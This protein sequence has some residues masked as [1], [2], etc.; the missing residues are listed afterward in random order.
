MRAFL[1]NRYGASAGAS[2]TALAVA[3][4]L[5]GCAVGPDFHAPKAPET[6]GY[7]PP[8][9]AADAPATH[10]AA[11][12]ADAANTPAAATN[13]PAGAPA[14][15]ATASGVVADS[16]QS[17]VSGLDIPGQWWT[18]FQSPQ[19]NALIERA[20]TRSPTL[21]A[22]QAALREANENLAAGRGA[23]YPSVSGSFQAEREKGTGASFG[24]PEFGSYLYSLYDASVSVS[25]TLD[26]FGA[27][28]RQ[29]ESLQA[30]SDYQRYAL[31]ASYLSLTANIVT[32]A[33]SEASVREQISQTEDIAR[34]Q[35][36]Q[37]DIIQR[38]V[39]AGA[40]SRTDVAQQQATLANTLATLPALRTQLAQY[41]NQLASYVGELPADFQADAFTLD[42]LTLPAELPVSLPSRLVEQR[43]D[44]QEY[45]AQLHQATAQVGVATANLLPQFTLSGDYGNDS[46]RIG[47]LL[48]PSN[49]VWGLVG[50]VTQPL[51]E[52][53][54]L[55]HQR[56]AAVAAAQQA[57]ANY[58]AS[59][60]NAFQEVA[61]ALVALQGDA[62]AV[63]ANTRAQQAAADSLNLIKAQYKSGG[64]SY[65]QVL[66]AEQSY[67]SAAIALVKA[68]ARRY[69]DTAAL[70]QAL[71]GG[72]WNRSD[73]SSNLSG[74]CK[75]SM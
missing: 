55:R 13:G 62:D 48:N 7:L 38:R 47:T 5:G 42:S 37:L 27:T 70:F 35:Q 28:R 53:G 39:T 67:Q 16:P 17:F 23:Y 34:S 9:T 33:V 56:R 24:Q 2:A 20:L 44:V 3:L 10:A 31:E 64:A 12:P 49:V 61:N 66:T 60:L 58:R 75:G 57:A 6:Q 52:G 43:P 21:E 15:G 72:W 30:Q 36:S 22:A 40:A 51:F 29:V 68:R 46:T 18:L 8:A 69:A 32:A 74:C 54:K 1:S 45:T 25:Y 26:V 14:S 63:G 4:V 73:V 65:T 71:G 11:A 59:V 41:R 19:L 50:G